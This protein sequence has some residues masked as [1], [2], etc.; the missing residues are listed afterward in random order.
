[1]TKL[2]SKA[3]SKKAG[4]SVAID[5]V[6]SGKWKM[7]GGSDRHQW[8]ERLSILVI[9]AL[10]VIQ[11]DAEIVS[12]AASAVTAGVVDMN[13]SD[14]IEGILISQIVVANEA[15]MNLYRLGWINS[16]E[17]LEASTKYLTLADKAAR[18][19]MMLTERL[20][21]HRNQ[22]KQQIVV[23]HTTTVNANQAVVTDSVVT[24]KKNE[25]SARL[26]AAVA[27]KPMEII[28]EVGKRK[29]TVPVVGGVT[30]PK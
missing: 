8:N 23:Q 14:P 30:K 25:A 1:M 6:P 16:G 10:P 4:V 13:P 12:N 5:A 11:K 21:H 15:A 24:G 22:G 18:T 19:A 29:E 20:D 26:L 9:N 3:L 17:Y 28:E 2:K 7:L 27:D